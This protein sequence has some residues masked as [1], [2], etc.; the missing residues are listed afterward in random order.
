MF[1]SARRRTLRSLRGT[2][3]AVPTLALAGVVVV[4]AG[5]VLY[6]GA[7]GLTRP[8]APAAGAAG[9]AGGSVLTSGGGSA[10]AAATPARLGFDAQPPTPTDTPVPP[11]P[12]PTA[13]PLPGPV[14]FT[15]ASGQSGDV[16]TYFNGRI[17]LSTTPGAVLNIAFGTCG[18]DGF[19]NSQS[20][21]HVGS[22][23]SW[24]SGLGGGLGFRSS[25]AI[26]FT[27]TLTASGTAPDGAPLAGSTTFT[28]S[29]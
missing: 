28:V 22:S 19:I 3:R 12:M 15:C 20:D 27:V 6:T 10:R 14:T 11:T 13:T 2:A 16:A 26:P 17:C 25:C 5:L 29:H 23:G 21:L 4:V 9:A 24:D 18:S 7:Q 8:A 1:T